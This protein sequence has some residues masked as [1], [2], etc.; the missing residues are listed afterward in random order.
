MYSSSVTSSFGRIQIG[1]CL[2]STS[3]SCVTF[4]TFFV[5]FSFFASSSVTSSTF[6]SSFSSPSFSSSS[7]S[8][9][10]SSSV[11]FSTHRRI[12]KPMNS[13]CFFTRSRI[14]RSSST[15][16]WSLLMCRMIF[17]PRPNGSSVDGRI[18]NEPPAADS[19]TYCSSS[20]FFEITSTR[21][22]TRYAE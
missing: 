18:V 11:V 8:S 1:F 2:F 15:S 3:H 10:T 22:A 14:V 9:G 6:G 5:F 20:L 19:H 21:S 7:S 12:G 13:E 16:S 4:F 17:V